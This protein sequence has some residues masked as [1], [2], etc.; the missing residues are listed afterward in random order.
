MINNA[1]HADVLRAVGLVE[2]LDDLLAPVVSKVH[3]FS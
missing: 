3:V 2:V 1:G